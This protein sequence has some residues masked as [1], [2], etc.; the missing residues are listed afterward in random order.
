M[1]EAPPRASPNMSTPTWLRSLAAVALVVGA[2]GALHAPI[3][4][5]DLRLDPNYADA[6]AKRGIGRPSR[7]ERIRDQ[8]HTD[9]SHRSPPLRRR[10]RK[11]PQRAP[12]AANDL[13]R[14]GDDDG[15]GRRQQV[16]VRQAREA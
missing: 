4:R 13:E 2:T 16:Q 10:D 11:H 12:A 1:N 3:A 14:C 6:L 5:Y 9:A 8:G 7:E 15:A